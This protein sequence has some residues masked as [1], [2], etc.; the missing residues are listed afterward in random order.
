MNLYENFKLLERWGLPHPC[1]EFVKSSKELKKFKRLKDYCG[2]TVKVLFTKD[3]VFRQPLYVNWLP[4]NKVPFQVDAFARQA[5]KDFVII[6]YPSW[7][8][9]KT[10]TLLIERQRLVVEACK[11]HIYEL[12]RKGNC[13]LRLIYDKDGK[14][15][16][17]WGNGKFLS[18]QERRKI[19]AAALRLKRSGIIL[20][21][22]VSQRKEFIVY[23][24]ENLK[25]AGKLLLAKYS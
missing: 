20:E 19:L 5:K 24:L 14:L 13:Q 21:W 12:M 8:L 11:G 25:Q 3:N 23:K 6:V 10:G 2:W 7:K 18:P 17:C 9:I 22:A 15:Q 16:E 4:K 1:W